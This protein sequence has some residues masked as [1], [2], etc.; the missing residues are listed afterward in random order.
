MPWVLV[1]VHAPARPGCL[2]MEVIWLLN[3]HPLTLNQKCIQVPTKEGVS[4]CSW[5]SKVFAS[6]YFPA[7]SFLKSLQSK[8]ARNTTMLEVLGAVFV[9][10]FRWGLVARFRHTYLIPRLDPYY[11][12]LS[13]LN[14]DFLLTL[15]TAS[16]DSKVSLN[17]DMT[18]WQQ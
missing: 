15:I 2:M 10:S 12:L 17:M 18:S 13:P 9:Y 4:A 8:E 7:E 6:R 14:F 1:S 5:L 3:S 11:C 16:K